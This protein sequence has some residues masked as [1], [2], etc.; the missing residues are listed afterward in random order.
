MVESCLEKD[1]RISAKTRTFVSWPQ[2]FCLFRGVHICIPTISIL[3]IQGSTH[4]YPDHKHFAYSGEFTLYILYI[5]Y[6]K[7]FTVFYT[8]AICLYMIMCLYFRYLYFIIWFAFFKMLFNLF[9]NKS[10]TDCPQSIFSKS[11]IFLYMELCKKLLSAGWHD[12]E[13]VMNNRYQW[14]LCA[15]I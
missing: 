3:H 11:I 9:K 4:L 2:T 7:Y 14:R 1:Q 13:D 8:V 5:V 10:L 15:P 12:I 6:K